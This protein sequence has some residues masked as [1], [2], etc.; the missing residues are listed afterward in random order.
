MRK[1][2]CYLCYLFH[3]RVIHPQFL[4]Q[5]NGYISDVRCVKIDT[6][7]AHNSLKFWFTRVWGFGS[8]FVGSESSL[9]SS[10]YDVLELEEWFYSSRCYLPLIWRVL[11]FIFM[12]LQF[13]LKGRLLFTRNLF[14]EDFKDSYLYFQLILLHPVY[15]FFFL[16]QSSFCYLCF[17]LCAFSSTMDF[18][19]QTNC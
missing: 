19:N 14:H 13:I 2:Y 17:I 10:S 6:C 15:Y 16:C 8:N 5:W 12:F 18:F 11:L 3:C 7:Q 9:E 4:T 1:C